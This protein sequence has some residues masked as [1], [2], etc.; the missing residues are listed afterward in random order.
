ML[1]PLGTMVIITIVFSQ[2]FHR[3]EKYPA[4]LLSGL[5]AWNFFA[6]TTNATMQQIVWGSRLFQRIYLP[7]TTFT[8]AA[9]G[10]GLV[11]FLFSL[12]PFF[13]I[14]FA[15]HVEFTPA[16]SILPISILLLSAFTLGVG[17]FFSSFAIFFPDVREMYQISLTAWMYLTPIIYPVD[18]LPENLRPFIINLNPMYH[19]IQLFRL[20]MYEGRFPDFRD[21]IISA[22][23]SLSAL[24]VGWYTFTKKASKIAYYV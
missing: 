13:I 11:N 3:V 6:Q 24:L 8:I 7:R 22:C 15:I 5:L 12:I 10:T 19:F 17:L 23:I 1:N 16:L 21:I 14:M 18:I 9:V 2:L 4:Y 20:P